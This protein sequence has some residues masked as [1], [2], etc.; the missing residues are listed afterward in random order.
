MDRLE[1]ILDVAAP[2]PLG[3]AA[4]DAGCPPEGIRALEA[5]GRI[6]RLDDDLAY[7]AAAFGRLE[8]M[9]LEMATRGALAPSALRDATGTSRKYVMAILEE[10][11]RRGVLQ[12]TP[13]GHVPGPRARLAA[14]R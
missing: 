1:S 13:D 3:A 4:R 14:G 6:I 2:P 10:L 12:R 5:A 7:A 11:D 8:A 9:A